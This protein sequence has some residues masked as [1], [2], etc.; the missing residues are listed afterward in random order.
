MDLIT[1]SLAARKALEK[2]GVKIDPS[3]V[4]TWDGDTS[5]AN[6]LGTVKIHDKYMDLNNVVSLTLASD[7]S[8]T[9]NGAV[10]TEGFYLQDV[11]EKGLQMLSATNDILGANA[12]NYALLV[13]VSANA[14]EE[15]TGMGLTEGVYVAAEDAQAHIAKITFASTITPIDLKFLP[16]ECTPAVIDLTKY[17]TTGG[18]MDGISINDQLLYMVN[19]SIE[20]AGA[21]QEVYLTLNDNFFCKACAVKPNVIVKTAAL[22][23]GRDVEVYFPTTVSTRRVGEVKFAMNMHA[24]ATLN[25]AGLISVEC[26][27][28]F[29]GDGSEVSLS[30]KATPFA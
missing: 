17:P 22:V 24:Y 23:S 12:T 14:T 3:K 16:D 7:V 25:L 11:P 27:F 28:V 9:H 1:I 26:C 18:V 10:V 6:E 15:V 2:L 21:V 30:I 19:A 29:G 13:S 4:L 8:Q 5:G 20:N